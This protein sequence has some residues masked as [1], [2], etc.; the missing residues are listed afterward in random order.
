M[1]VSKQDYMIPYINCT[2][3]ALVAKYYGVSEATINRK[4]IVYKEE[5]DKA[6]IMTIT[7]KEFEGLFPEGARYTR[8][9]DRGVVYY[10]FENGMTVRVSTVR[11]HIFTAEA[12]E[13]MGELL[14]IRKRKAVKEVKENKDIVPKVRV[15][16]PKFRDVEEKRLCLGLAKAFASGDTLKVLNAALDLDNYRIETIDALTRENERLSDTADKRLPWTDRAAANRTVK[17]IAAVLE[18]NQS[19]IWNK[20]Y[21]KLTMDYKLPLES[22]HKMP[23]IDAVEGSEWP[24]VYQAISEVCHEKCL[25]TKR[26]FEKAGINVNGLMLKEELR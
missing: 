17:A 6:G 7:A 22:R 20:V 2:T 21:F 3:T 18:Q 10:G 9:A 23:L 15:P 4:C 13:Y 26:I 19:D 16:A 11:N 8:E 14:K 12:M 24:L 1:D 25:D 5:L